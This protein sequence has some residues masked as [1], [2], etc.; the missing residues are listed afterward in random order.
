MDYPEEYG[1]TKDSSLEI[2]PAKGDEG[3]SRSEQSAFAPE[4]P[5]P[6][7]TC[8]ECGLLEFIPREQQ[9]TMFPCHHIP[10]NTRG[11]TI[12]SLQN[13]NHSHWIEVSL[14]DWLRRL[15]SD[16]KS[17]VWESGLRTVF[18]KKIQSKF[19]P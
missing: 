9:T 18:R 16:K 2:G 3:A 1:A 15:P 12:A 19:E 13:K 7:G 14:C 8:E 11:D 5:R 6:S 10:L 4:C 17:L